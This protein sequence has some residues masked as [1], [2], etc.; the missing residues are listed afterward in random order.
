M[1]KYISLVYHCILTVNFI[2]AFAIRNCKDET[3]ILSKWIS[4]RSKY[5]NL[6]ENSGE[7]AG[8]EWRF[9][10]TLIQSYNLSDEVFFEIIKNNSDSSLLE[11]LELPVQKVNFLYSKWKSFDSN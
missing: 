11:R 5:K 6:V 7:L 3:N 4:M 10:D 9:N 2:Q 1:L 8:S